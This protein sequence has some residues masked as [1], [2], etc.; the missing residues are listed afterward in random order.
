MHK[1]ILQMVFEKIQYGGLRVRYWDGEEVDY[2]DTS[3]TVKLLFRQ[4]PAALFRLEDP[5]MILGEAYM[6]GVLDFEGSL[7][8]ILVILSQNYAALCSKGGA[9]IKALKSIVSKSDKV[10]AK[11]NIAHHYDLGNNFFSL[12]LDKTMSYS[13]AYFEHIDDSL[14]QAQMQKIDHTL[15]KL[16]LQPNETLL[17]I[18][19]GWGCLIIKA[20]QAYKVKAMGI[21]LS[22]EQYRKTQ[23]QISELGLTEKVTVKLMNYLDLDEKEY[24][25]DKIVSVGMFEHVGK[26]NIPQYFDKVKKLLIP[27]GL[28]LL[29]TIT[30]PE[31]E[32]SNTW[33]KAYIFPGGYVPSI[34]E[35]LK[36]FRKNDFHLL[37]AESLR[38][39][40]ALTLD[41]WYQNFTENI[42]TINKMFDERF[43]RM[44]ELYLRGCAAA[45]RSTGLDIHQILFSKGL[46]NEL[47]LTFKLV[48]E[49]CR[50]I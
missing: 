15:Q 47:P 24:Q 22:E 2:G 7:E 23:E 41:Q 36:Y 5:T 42:N 29:H 1:Q 21:T 40:Y 49:E 37:H 45:F 11:S 17:D 48:K 27:G 16:N 26:E 46:N 43:I 35:V 20:A 31:E 10:Q 8:D 25:F 14:E 4:S 18:G 19:S 13:C 32:R 44:W 12:W 30:S 3:P 6:D 34:L 38:M 50:K 33:I 28:S 39:H 9:V